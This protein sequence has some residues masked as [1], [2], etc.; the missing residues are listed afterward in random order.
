[1]NGLHYTVAEYVRTFRFGL[2]RFVAPSKAS[3][4]RF[5]MCAAPTSTLQFSPLRAITTPI[6][7]SCGAG[8]YCLPPRQQKRSTSHLGRLALTRRA[9]L[10]IHHRAPFGEWFSSPARVV[11][12]EDSPEGLDCCRSPGPSLRLTCCA[13]TN[14]PGRTR[15]M[16]VGK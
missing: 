13:E 1:M 7:D 11:M 14:S 9:L 6:T 2:F 5:A 16:A 12:I 4:S 10:S 15:D 3:P 8:T